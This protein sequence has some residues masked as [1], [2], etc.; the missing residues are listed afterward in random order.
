MVELGKIFH[1]KSGT[2]INVVPD[3]FNNA[4]TAVILS[5]Y[6]DISSELEY[7][8]CKKI[9]A[10]WMDN[11]FIP[12]IKN[13]PPKFYADG[14]FMGNAA[15]RG[16][17]ERYNTD[18]LYN[19]N[20]R[21]STISIEYRNCKFNVN[22]NI[23]SEHHETRHYLKK[24]LMD[25]PLYLDTMMVAITGTQFT[26]DIKDIE[27]KKKLLQLVGSDYFNNIDY[28]C[29]ANNIFLR[30]YRPFF[31]AISNAETFIEKYIETEIEKVLFK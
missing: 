28:W 8:L 21:N 11:N 13:I 18:I 14:A 1:L 22:S 19:L 20:K 31:K 4:G 29:Y 25:F 9:L 10:D 30:G 24:V 12:K 16:T 27:D 6:N 15:H 23:K 5:S 3:A 26:D 7:F 17:Y 2:T